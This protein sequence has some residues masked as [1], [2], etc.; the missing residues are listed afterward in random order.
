MPQMGYDM[1]EGTIVRWLKGEGASVK[2]GEAIAEIETDKAIVEFESYADGTLRMILV[3]EGSTVPVGQTIAVVA[4]ATE[5][6]SGFAAAPPPDA[7][8]PAEEIHEET[9]EPAVSQEHEMPVQ[10]PAPIPE[11]A[12]T[13]AAGPSR[14]SPLARRL[15]EERGVNIDDI[16]GTGPGGRVVK[17]DVLA[18]AA[19]G[20]VAAAGMA[21]AGLTADVPVAEVEEAHAAG[22]RGG[23]GR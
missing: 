23:A 11:P 6:L 4:E 13:A 21:P 2:M 7:E 8:P 10:A 1:Q 22:G 15:A 12:P 14:A 19:A 17:D 18:F 9:A 3:G 20:P 16:A 5:D